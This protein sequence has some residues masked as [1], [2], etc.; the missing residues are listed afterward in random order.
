MIEAEL[1]IRAADGFE[2]VVFCVVALAVAVLM[3]KV[4]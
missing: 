2:E 1:V 3:R 4:E